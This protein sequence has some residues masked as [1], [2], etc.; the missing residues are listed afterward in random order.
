MGRAVPS[1]PEELLTELRGLDTETLVA[2]A[3]AYVDDDVV[4]E[5]LHG[6]DPVNVPMVRHFCEAIGDINPIYLDEEAA[7]GTRHKGLIAPPAMLGVWT[8]GTARNA[9]GPRDQVLRRLDAAGFTSVVATD[10]THEYLQPVR[11]GDRIHERR[12]IEDLVGPKRT[13]LGEGFFVT[14]RYDYHT[15]D[16]TLVGIGRMRLLKF[17]PPDAPR[18]KATSSRPPM[19]RPRPPI[20][21]DNAFFWEGVGARELRIQRCTG[22]GELRHPPG[23][24]CPQCR[25]TDW[26][27]VVASGRG[28]IFSHAV[29]HHPPLPGTEL[30]HAVVLV[31]LEEGVRFLSEV[32][33]MSHRDLAIGMPVE[34]VWKTIDEDDGRGGPGLVVPAFAPAPGALPAPPPPPCVLEDV[35]VGTELP[36]FDVEMTPTFIVSAALASRDFEEVHHDA[37]IARARGSEDLFPNILTSNGLALRIVTDWL[38]PDAVVERAAVRLGLPAYVGE[39]LEM[40]AEVTRVTP[41]PETGDGEVEVAVRGRISTGDHLTGTVVASLPMG[42]S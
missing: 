38:G 3:R 7:A 24:M 4:G 32:D 8:M 41:R 16:G 1:T 11:P 34:L 21:R 27:W 13:A 26:D 23:P 20:N 40:R 42:D 9:G 5:P 14:S 12:S 33:G 36:G 29:H 35:V 19:R 30:P 10:Y 18:A 6:P 25:S 2:Q 17:R 31:E 37:E 28:T 39:V 15:A 22:C